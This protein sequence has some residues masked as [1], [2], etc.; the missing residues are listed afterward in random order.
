MSDYLAS[1]TTETFSPDN[2]I[3]GPADLI[4]SRKVTIDAGVLARGA[5]LGKITAGGKYILSASAAVDGSQVPDAILAHAVDATAADQ[6]AMVYMRGDFAEGALVLGAG[7]TAD[8]I[9]EGLRDK[10]ITLVKTQ[11]AV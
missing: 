6:E 1:R 8:S 3:A 2:L 10:G 11:P 5:V 7:H 9:R 4:V